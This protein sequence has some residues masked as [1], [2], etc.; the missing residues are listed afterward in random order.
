MLRLRRI[1]LEEVVIKIGDNIHEI[2]NE[3]MVPRLPTEL[4]V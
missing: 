4:E 3:Y 1:N 2:E